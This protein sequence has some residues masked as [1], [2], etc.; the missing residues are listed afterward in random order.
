[1]SG[2]CVHPFKIEVSENEVDR[3]RRKLEDTR[4]PGREIVTG[5]GDRYGPSYGWASGLVH[6]WIHDFDW[7]QV[8]KSINEYPHYRTNVEG[9][10]IHFLHAR[11]EKNDAI[12]LLLI[13]GW[14]GSFY[15]F[16]R[17]WG[18]LSHPTDPKE[19]AFHVVVPSLPG[20]CWSD[21]PPRA[22]WTLKDT[23]RIFD[24][25]MKRLGYYKYMVQC[26]DW[27]SFVGRELGATYTESCKLLHLN[28]CPSALPDRIEPTSREA[29]VSHRVGDFLENH[30]GYAICMRTRPHTIGIAL[31]DNP[32][33]ILMWVGEKYIEAADPQKQK[34]PSW[35]QAI[36][37]TASLYYFTDCI[38]PS[39]LCYYE[40]ERH[41]NFAQYSL[42]PENQV[43]VPF[44]YSSFFWDTEPSSKRAVERTGNLVFYREHDDGGHFAALENHADICQDLRDLV[45]QEWKF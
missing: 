44:G 33:G 24:Q 9:I 36:L 21:R 11:A 3:L 20:F 17:V 13:H 26:G 4:L 41:E 12:P 19:Q 35:T 31:N 45:S 1:M 6:S 18:P 40:N 27:G 38:M 37:T 30:L 23:A 43:K 42:R 22:G 28:F 5:A 14:P 34:C 7:F 29:E 16:S 32:V 25:I 39:M 2:S 15:E 10:N 8:Q